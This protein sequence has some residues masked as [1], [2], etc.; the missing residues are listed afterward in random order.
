M[1]DREKFRIG[2]TRERVF[3]R[4]HWACVVCGAPAN[5]LAHRIPQTKA[6]LRRY[7]KAVIHH[8]MNLA[9]VCSLRCNS[10][11]LIHGTEIEALVDDISR[12]IA[13]R[14]EARV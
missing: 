11:V 2:E 8:D 14:E 7:G 6:N 9:S 10:A 4:D 5:Q 3:A 1:T 12:H 13:R